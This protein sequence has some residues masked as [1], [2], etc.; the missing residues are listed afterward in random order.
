ML[1]LY[2]AH[3]PDRQRT[4]AQSVLDQIK[5]RRFAKLYFQARNR[6]N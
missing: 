6:V 5:P 3:A 1:S 4:H 2:I